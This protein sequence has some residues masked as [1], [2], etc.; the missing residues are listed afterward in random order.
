MMNV[1]A[2]SLFGIKDERVSSGLT[3]LA[4]AVL[5]GKAKESLTRLFGISTKPVNSLPGAIDLGKG[6]YF[7]SGTRLSGITN[8]SRDS[9]VILA[10]GGRKSAEELVHA[11]LNERVYRCAFGIKETET[12]DSLFFLGIYSG[13]RIYAVSNQP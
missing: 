13:G 9:P 2:L 4:Q 1:E 6:V 3:R 11:R 7:H 8:L 10:V 12:V 5:D